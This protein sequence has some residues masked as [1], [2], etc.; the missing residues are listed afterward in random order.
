MAQHNWYAHVVG[1]LLLPVVLFGSV[2]LATA[3]SPELSQR[4]AP[5]A[6]HTGRAEDA[7]YPCAS[8]ECRNPFQSWLAEDDQPP[9]PVCPYTRQRTPLEHFDL[10]V[11]TMTGIVWGGLGQHALISA[12]DRHHHVVRV[13]S[14]LGQHCGRV[15][16]ITAEHLVIAEQYTQQ[17]AVVRK[18]HTLFLPLAQKK[19]QSVH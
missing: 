3:G 19:A 2:G 7:A 14:A 10:S 15:A 18:D 5:Q 11:L 12:P 6:T 8:K 16:A 13:G 4:H 1:A 9:E 17:G